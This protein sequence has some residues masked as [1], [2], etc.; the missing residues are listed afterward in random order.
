MTIE[1]TGRHRGLGDRRYSAPSTRSRSAAAATP[2]AS[3]APWRDRRPSAELLP[4]HGSSL[5]DQVDKITAE[6]HRHGAV[7][8]DH[9]QVLSDVQR[10]VA[11]IA[12]VLAEHHATDPTDA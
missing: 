4:N 9:T 12:V 1:A 5:R 8:A 7:L 3:C 10:T 6:Q 11:R 2:A